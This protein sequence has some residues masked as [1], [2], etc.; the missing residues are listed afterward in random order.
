VSNS[1]GRSWGE[2]G[3]FRILKGTNAC[4]IED[5]VIAAWADIDDFDV[6]IHPQGY[7]IFLLNHAA[8]NT[9]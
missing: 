1:W 8:A 9:V 5:F 6:T 2:N 7:D 4:Q 3:Y